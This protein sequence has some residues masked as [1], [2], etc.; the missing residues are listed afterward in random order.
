MSVPAKALQFLEA[1]R[2]ERIGMI[3]AG[4]ELE[5]QSTSGLTWGDC[6][7]STPD[8]DAYSD[9]VSD[10]VD[11]IVGSELSAYLSAP[12]YSSV[13]DHIIQRVHDELDMSNY[14]SSNGDLTDTVSIPAGIQVGSDGTVS[15]FEFRTGNGGVNYPDFIRLAR[16]LFQI[17]H[18]IDTGC[19]FHIH[20]SVVGVRHKFGERLQAAMVEFLALNIESVPESVR[21]RWSKIDSNSYIRKL[22]GETDK[23]CFIRSH[24]QGTWEFRCFGN[25]KNAK[26]AKKCL[27]LSIAA[28]AHGYAVIQGEAA[29]LRDKYH[30]VY[31]NDIEWQDA[32]YASLREGKKLKAFRRR[33]AIAA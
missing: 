32:V 29:L 12:V 5:T 17:P 33:K 2:I 20:L 14:T 31:G 15:G 6:D 23:Y 27:D 1:R 18:S 16:E 28:L 21:L 10:R 3:K 26:D 24:P 11:E 7:G 19:S 30:D 9:A 4:F 25:V 8:E 22:I 13:R